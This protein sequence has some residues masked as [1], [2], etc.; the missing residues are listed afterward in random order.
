[1]IWSKRLFTDLFNTLSLW[2]LINQYGPF[3]NKNYWFVSKIILH[4]HSKSI[5]HPKHKENPT[6]KHQTEEKTI[7]IQKPWLSL[8]DYFP[9]STQF[10]QSF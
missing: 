10:Y 1:M 6:K 5:G 9:L 7:Y 2:Y 8:Y 3:L 4:P